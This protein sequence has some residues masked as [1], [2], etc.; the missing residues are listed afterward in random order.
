MGDGAHG[1]STTTV[2]I[3]QQGI[4]GAYMLQW[5][6]NHLQLRSLWNK[7]HPLLT[8]ADL[9]IFYYNILK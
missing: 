7:L 9:M 5:K 2:H 8:D 6:S 4:Q 3:R 1:L